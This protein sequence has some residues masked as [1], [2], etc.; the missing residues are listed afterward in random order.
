MLVFQVQTSRHYFALKLVCLTMSIIVAVN[1][2]SDISIPTSIQIS[3]SSITI[4][5]YDPSTFFCLLSSVCLP[6]L[7]LNLVCIYCILCQSSGLHSSYR[8]CLLQ[9]Q[10]SMAVYGL[11]C[12]VGGSL[13]FFVTTDIRKQS[14]YKSLILAV[15]RRSRGVPLAVHLRLSALALFCTGVG[16]FV[17]QFISPFLEESET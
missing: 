1:N 16:A 13:V 4:V 10:V 5:D 8:L 15:L 17:S 11:A 2:S 12:L 3:T 9:S 6:E 7:L 14:N